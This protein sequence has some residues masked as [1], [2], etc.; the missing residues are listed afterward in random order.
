MTNPC[1]SFIFLIVLA[2]HSVSVS[3]EYYP[4]KYEHENESLGDV[5]PL[6]IPTVTDRLDDLLS[7]G[8]YHQ[9]CPNLEAI[10]SKKVKEWV[11]KDFTI[12]A[13]LLR[14]H[15]HDCAVRV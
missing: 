5:I 9:S 14:L 2:I 3:S 15:F 7:F 10:I 6:T 4:N 13:S 12:A 8:Y 1:V 11:D